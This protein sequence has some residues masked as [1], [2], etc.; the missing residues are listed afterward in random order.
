MVP[1][2]LNSRLGVIN[3]GLTLHI[4]MG[5]LFTKHD[6]T[7]GRHGGGEITGAPTSNAPCNLL[8]SIAEIKQNLRSSARNFHQFAEGIFT[9]KI[10]SGYGKHSHGSHGPFI[11]GLPIKN[12]GSFHGELVVITRW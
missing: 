8:T 1:S 2:Q 3:P 7:W 12:G 6:L 9:R 4:L 11:D 10:P 5:C